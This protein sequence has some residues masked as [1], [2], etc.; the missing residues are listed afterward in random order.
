MPAWAPRLSRD[1]LQT[2]RETEPSGDFLLLWRSRLR[3]VAP[4]ELKREGQG[5][6]GTLERLDIRA[7]IE[8]EAAGMEWQALSLFIEGE[9]A[10][11]EENGFGAVGI[12]FVV[13]LCRQGRQL[14][15]V[16]AL[17]VHLELQAK[18]QRRKERGHVLG[19]RAG[20]A[21]R[22]QFGG[23]PW[24]GVWHNGFLL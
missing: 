3:R 1:A 19:S 21:E 11:G 17:L 6:Q 14:R 20:R 4:G 24:S 12:V 22:F 8:P 2:D 18:A 16:V 7:S 5:G 10:P 23:G 15:G 9:I 13:V